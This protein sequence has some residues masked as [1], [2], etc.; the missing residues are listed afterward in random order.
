MLPRWLPLLVG[1]GT[2]LAA[3]SSRPARTVIPY[4]AELKE[5][6]GDKWLLRAAQIQ[7]ESAFDPN[8]VS[9]DHGEGLG[10]AT[11]IWPMYERNGWVPKGSTP[12]QVLPAVMGVHRYMNYLFARLGTHHK[13]LGGYN[14]GE[15]NVERA[16]VAA[17]IAHLPGEDAWLEA[18]PTITHANAQ[19]TIRYIKNNDRTLASYI[20]RGI[21]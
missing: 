9:F 7:C 20:R 2:V 8:A 4:T 10:Q 19:Y 6:C 21:K 17:E 11:N 15:K 5:V 14:A 3:A 12:F 18:L 13:A 16:T 1:A